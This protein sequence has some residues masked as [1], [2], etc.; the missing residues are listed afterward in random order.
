MVSYSF[1]I[2][3]E[4]VG[5]VV[6][7]RGLRQG[8]AIS[9]YLFV[10]CAEFLSRQ[11]AIVEDG[12]EFQGV[13]VCTGAPA[14]SHLFF[15]DESFVFFKAEERGCRKVGSILSRYETLSGQQ[16]S[17]AKS[18][19]AFSRNVPRWKQDELT[20]VL[21]VKRVEKHKKYLGLPT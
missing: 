9:P 18:E 4:P 11:F 19:I 3:G 13:R 15:T 1:I 10:I 7:S 16:V 21:G 6:P 20:A 2:N 12:D 14:I 17:L 5:E 8:D